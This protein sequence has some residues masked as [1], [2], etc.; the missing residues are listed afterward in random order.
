MLVKP[1]LSV[2]TEAV[3]GWTNKPDATR[4]GKLFLAEQITLLAGLVHERRTD[5]RFGEWLAEAG[6]RA[7]PPRTDIA[8]RERRFAN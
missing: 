8:S 4:G 2:L 1:R 6:N 5:P 7:S 3:L